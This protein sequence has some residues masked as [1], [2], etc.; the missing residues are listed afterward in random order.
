[1]RTCICALKKILEALMCEERSQDEVFLKEFSRRWRALLDQIVVT[2]MRKKV[3]KKLKWFI[4]EVEKY[5]EGEMSTLGY[6]LS[7]CAGLTWLPFPYMDLLQKLHQDYINNPAKSPLS[8]WCL[9]LEEA[10]QYLNSE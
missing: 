9:C 10:L 7:E 6:Y 1:M 2:Q 5:P 8:H 3:L 4:Q